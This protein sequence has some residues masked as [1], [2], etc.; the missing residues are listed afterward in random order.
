MKRLFKALP[1]VVILLV[2][3][4]AAFVAPRFYQLISPA[5]TAVT[6]STR[7]RRGDVTF[8]VYANGTLQGGNS[9]MVTAP[10]TGSNSL[11]I[12]ELGKSGAG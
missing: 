7:V 3:G 2:A 5:S 6:P 11:T 1:V 12:T 8:T 9:K 4:A 10:M